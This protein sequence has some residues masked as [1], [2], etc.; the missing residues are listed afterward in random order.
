MTA[1]VPLRSLH[2]S[3]PTTSRCP[4][5]PKRPPFVPSVVPTEVRDFWVWEELLS[6]CIHS[7]DEEVHADSHCIMGY[8]RALHGVQGSPQNGR[9]L[10]WNDPDCDASCHVKSSQSERWGPVD[11]ARVGGVYRFY[12]YG[13]AAQYYAIFNMLVCV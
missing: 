8:L 1:V 10:G 13:C 4:Q 6:S 2:Q 5:H 7:T 9:G 3:P 11:M 12:L